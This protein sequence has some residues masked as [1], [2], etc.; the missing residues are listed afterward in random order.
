MAIIIIFISTV[1]ILI[2]S[3]F[4]FKKIFKKKR[5]NYE[6]R[7]SKMINI[8]EKENKLQKNQNVDI[9]FLGD[10]LIF[11][12]NLKQFF[13]EYTTLNR[14][15]GG[16]TTFGVEK[17]LNVSCF[18]IKSKLI[19]MLIGINNID[20]MLKNYESILIKFKEKANERKIILCSLT[21]LGRKKSIKKNNLIISNNKIIKNLAEKY[22]FIYIDLF[23]PLFNEKIYKIFP[24]YTWDGLHF[25]DEGYNVITK[26]I[27]KVLNKIF[28]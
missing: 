20:S 17:R 26:E 12:Y 13:P 3:Y 5:I 7:Y 18:D 2:L 6:Q 28:S 23:T 9:I 11:R 19:V 27:K 24:Q 16:D 1:A 4:I 15:I 21:P 8:Y 25:T 14:G 10:S 22:N